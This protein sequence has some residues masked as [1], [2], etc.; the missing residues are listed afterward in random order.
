LV[1]A[2][3]QN[4]DEADSANRCGKWFSSEE[5]I[6]ITLCAEEIP[7]CTCTPQISICLPHHWV[8]LI[9]SA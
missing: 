6:G 9:S 5:M 4:G 2:P 3:S 7:M 1:S 8:R